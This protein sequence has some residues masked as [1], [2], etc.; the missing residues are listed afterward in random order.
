MKK[1][2]WWQEWRNCSKQEKRWDWNRC[3]NKEA[4]KKKR[5]LLR[6]WDATRQNER[7]K[8]KTKKMKWRKYA[9][10]G[11]NFAE[12][13]I[14]LWTFFYVIPSSKKIFLFSS[15]GGKFFCRFLNFE[16]L[17]DEMRFF[18][19]HGC[20][21]IHKWQTWLNGRSMTTRVRQ[22]IVQLN[23]VFKIC[24]SNGGRALGSRID[25]WK[26]RRRPTWKIGDKWR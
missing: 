24:R 14:N 5:E 21:Y 9:A 7:D 13:D 17:R 15:S 6:I 25:Q 19:S 2:L 26:A 23:R 20:M 8:K 22:F 18:R 10:L 11:P 1:R 12:F 4:E 3:A 16:P